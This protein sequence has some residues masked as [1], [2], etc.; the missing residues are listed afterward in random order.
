MS[1]NSFKNGYKL[2]VNKRVDKTSV[3]TYLVQRL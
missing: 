1:N 2:I 3:I